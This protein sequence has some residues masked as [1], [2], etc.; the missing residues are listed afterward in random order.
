M[1]TCF[2]HAKK[3]FDSYWSNSWIVNLAVWNLWYVEE[4]VMWFPRIK[5]PNEDSVCWITGFGKT[6]TLEEPW[7]TVWCYQGSF[8]SHLQT[9]KMELP[10]LVCF[11]CLGAW[12]SCNVDWIKVCFGMVHLRRG[13]Y[14]MIIYNM[15]IVRNS[16]FNSLQIAVFICL[17][18]LKCYL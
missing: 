5:M 12:S 13:A 4:D 11:S 1:T 2:V 8:L 14:N 10:L 15:I 7:R 9:Q 18:M 3:V 16:V 17:S 6:F